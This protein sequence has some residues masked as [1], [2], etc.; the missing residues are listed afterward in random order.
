[1]KHLVAAAPDQAYTVTILLNKY[2]YVVGHIY[3]CIY[4]DP[5]DP[6]NNILY[7]QHLQTTHSVVWYSPTRS[8][9]LTPTL[10]T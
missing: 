6:I 4:V 8:T 10:V 2:E 9:R 7:I 3:L 1:M 5:G